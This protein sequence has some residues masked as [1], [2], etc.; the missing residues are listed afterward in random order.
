MRLDILSNFQH[1][2][3]RIRGCFQY[4][5]QQKSGFLVM[6]TETEP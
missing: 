4:A 1:I 6:D 5:K 3:D 2:A